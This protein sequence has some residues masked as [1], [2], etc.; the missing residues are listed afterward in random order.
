MLKTP[1]ILGM[2]TIPQRNRRLLVMLT[3][4]FLILIMAIFIQ[5][6]PFEF[7]FYS[8]GGI[9]GIIVSRLIFGKL[10]KDRVFSPTPISQT[11]ILSLLPRR[12]SKDRLD[13]REIALS[14]ASH[15]EAFRVIAYFSLFLWCAMPILL[16]NV[17]A[18][19]MNRIFEG[20]VMFLL[21]LAFTLPQA[22][23]LWTEPDV[24]EDVRV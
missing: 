13:E 18:Q 11:I 12:R 1:V 10:V 5:I 3:Y 24:P 7:P 23:F 19:L 17:N 15:Y 2:S 4:V 14:N 20:I 21:V 16:D 8:A 22:I 6:R 9:I